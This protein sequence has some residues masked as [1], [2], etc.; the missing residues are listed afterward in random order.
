MTNGARVMLST[1]PART[2]SASPDRTALAAIATASRLD[3]QSRFTVAARRRDRQ[4]R[5]QGRHPG[6][7]AVVLTGL[8][9]AADQHVVQLVPVDR[10]QPI[11]QSSRSTWAARSSGRTAAS[12]PPYR[13]NGVRTP[14]TR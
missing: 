3:P 13:P 9:G 7:V 11:G 5:Q 12:A 14:A 1:P 2:R 8:I 6:D 4:A 10:R